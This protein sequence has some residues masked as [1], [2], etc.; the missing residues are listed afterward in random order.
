[1]HARTQS[2][3]ILD[4]HLAL[5][6]QCANTDG[7]LDR[8]GLRTVLQS[9]GS[10]VVPT[11][12]L[13][14][15][16]VDAAMDAYDSN[17]DGVISVKEFEAMAKDNVFL[18]RS[19]N[20]YRQIFDRLDTGRNGLIGPTELYR[21]FEDQRCG[22]GVGSFERVERLL[23]KYDLNNDGSINFSEFLRLC[24]YEAVL[25]L[26]E[27]LCYVTGGG[28]VGVATEEMEE[29]AAKTKTISLDQTKVHVLKSP[30]EFDEIMAGVSDTTLVVMFASLTWC[31]PCK[32]LQPQMEKMA[33]AY[34]DT[35]DVVFLKIYGNESDALKTFFKDSLKVRVTPSVF[36][37]MGG[38][39]VSSTTGAN[40]TK[41]EGEIR[42]VLGARAADVTML[43]P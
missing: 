25:P 13:T 37:F 22:D 19:L 33:A 40:A 38:E 34:G 41:H 5:F 32:K 43:Y 31:R 9:V 30:E 14:D 17:K 18:L 6:A 15:A 16:D 27:I 2:T 29:K 39:L 8:N 12:W 3:S 35:C 26:E 36:L 42:R 11:D 10:E 20:E 4:R 24:R 21:Y 28:Q 7:N 23:K 1:M